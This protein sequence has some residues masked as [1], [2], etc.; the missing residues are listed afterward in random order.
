MGGQRS[1][2]ARILLTLVV[3][4]LSVAAYGEDASLVLYLSFD[5]VTAGQAKDLSPYGNHGTVGGNA[6][7]TQGQFGDALLFDATDDQVV[8]P[9]NPTL[10][11]IK[12]ITMMIWARPGANLTA[13][14]RTL[15][16][17]APTSVLGQ[18][19][20]SYDIRTDNT[21]ILR[22]SLNLDGTW[23]SILGPTA[24]QDTWY[25]VAGTYDGAQMVFYINGESVGT[26]P[27]TGAIRVTTDPVCVGNLVTAAG[28][29]QNEYWS[30]VLD[31]VRLWNRALT[32]AEVKTNMGQGQQGVLGAERAYEPSPANQE[33]DVP[34]DTALTWTAGQFAVS[35]DVYLGPV[36]ADVNAA[37]RTSPPGVLLSRG[38]SDTRLAPGALAFGQ[39]YFWRVDEVNAPPD[40]TIF[41]GDIWSFTV[42][43]YAYPIAPVAATASSFQ[44]G[45]GPENTIDGSG[46]TDDRH[47]TE[48]MTMWISAGGQPAWIQYEFDKV[49]LLH[50][51]MVWNA[52]QAIE[53]F[54][55]FGAKSVTIETSVDGTAWAPVADVPEFRRAPGTPD[56][57]ANT[58]VS[59]GEAEAKYVKLTI[60]SNW[61]GVAPQTGLSEV[62]FFYVPLEAR[63]PVP[64][65]GATDIDLATTLDWRPGRKAASHRV[66]FGTDADAV[67][68]GTA[69]AE[70]VADHG[71]VPEPLDLGATYYWKVDEV[72]TA[73]YPGSIWSFRTQEYQVVEDFESYTDAPGEEVFATWIDGFDNPTQN[74]AVVG[75]A[76]SVNGTFCDGT[77]F[78]GGKFSVPFAYDNT[79]APVS[80]ATRTFAPAVDWTASGIKSLSLWF[81]G[82]AGDTGQLY[83]KINGTKVLYGGAAADLARATWQV[84]NIDLSQAGSIR[85]V[86]T[87]TIGVEGAGAQGT[88]Y[89]DDIRLYPQTPGPGLPVQPA[90]APAAYYKLDGDYT[91]ASGHGRNGTAVGNPTF[92]AGQTGQAVSLDGTGDYITIDN[93]QGILGSNPFT[94]SLW[95]NSAAQDDRTMVCWGGATNGTRVDFRLYQGRLRVEHGNGNLQGNTVLADGQWHHTALVVTPGATLVYP[96]VAL[97]VDGLNDTQTTVDPD[98]FG[99]AADVPV[100][101]GQRRTNNDRDFQGLLDEVRIFD[102]ALSPEEVAGLAGRTAPIQRPF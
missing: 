86:R 80:E 82:A 16:G 75:L 43:P 29:A 76:A 79:A 24:T 56:Y 9:P 90:Q 53:P 36:F 1:R 63:A 51:L 47:G 78:H 71:Y 52:N 81:Q 42:E 30:G 22:F 87:L 10:D 65:D 77:T 21:G 28:V 67:T 3:A 6:A 13:D 15:M 57:P 59:L 7:V 25:H 26:L 97:Y 89:L 39:T 37:D 55:G 14:W 74:G 84:W 23:R 72:N 98:P 96:E 45:M 93:W 5:D 62:R 2:R 64:A 101:L 18:N 31:E 54:L 35:H 100:T 94:I 73:T 8:V 92:A 95:V 99:T 44:P 68:R 50:E 17:K 102:V 40:S 12:E 60:N 34:R 20:F 27:I 48:P 38:Q 70:T 49:Y 32:Q 85:S 4:F 58:T 83:V 11:I 61:G 33:I 46:L 88:L 91:D 41:K 69:P 19:T 66:Y